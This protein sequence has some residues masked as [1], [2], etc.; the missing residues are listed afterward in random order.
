MWLGGTTWHWAG[1]TPRFIPTDFKMKTRYGIGEDW[2]LTYDEL[3]PYYSEAEK[4]M[5]VCGEANN[6]DGSPRSGAFPLPPMPKTYLEKVIIS[7][8]EKKSELRFVPRP[9]ARN[10][11]EYKGRSQCQGFGTCSP[12]C[13]SGAQ[14]AAITHVEMA[15]KAGARVLAN[16][17]VDRVIKDKHGKV[18]GVEGH[19]ENNEKFSA[20]GKIVII[21]ANGIET[22]KIL[23]M[24]RDESS[25]NGLANKS[26]Q[27]GRNYMDHPGIFC[28]FLMPEPV[29]P[30][31]G[32]ETTQAC[33]TY[34]GGAFRKDSSAWTLTIYNR[35]HL[36]AIADELL[37]QNLMPLELD[38]V[39]QD[40]V[41]RQVEMDVGL[42]QLPNSEN[43]V[44]LNWQE[45]D[46][47]GQPKIKLYN[48]YRE[49][50]TK[51]FAR[52]RKELKHIVGLLDGEIVSISEPFAHH[53]LM[54][55][56]R[57]GD[58]PN[59]S[60][61]DKD[62]RTHEHDNLF[63]VSTSLFTTGGTANPTLTIAALALRTAEKIEQQLL[64][65]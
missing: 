24:S 51:S 11:R 8:L 16:M 59:T 15:E 14:Y 65:N 60:V 41:L 37:K 54:G 42:E 18:L 50:E 48:K 56:T 39:L 5:G 7:V 36:H 43:R 58:N 32:P 27:V 21:A 4:E 63:I 53:H 9:S 47:A 34:R 30:G 44:T 31:R 33:F 22:A 25:P 13:P 3:E 55:T 20:K 62:G 35:T 6:N 23:L 1:V 49:Y 26:D 38:K 19:N 61:T 52:L 28:R 12:I 64:R 29:Y 10:T 46:S 40:R 17:L 45:K 2:P 57:M